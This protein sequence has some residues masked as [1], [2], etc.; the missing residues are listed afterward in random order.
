MVVYGSASTVA[1]L[2]RRLPP[3]TPLV[4]YGHRLSVAVFGA[5]AGPDAAREVARAVAAFDQRGCVCPHQ[6]FVMGDAT[7]ARGIAEALADALR[8]LADDVPIGPSA[9]GRASA[10]QQLRGTALARRAA[11]EGVSVWEGPGV[12]W[13][14]VLDPSP[15]LR[16][17]CLGRTVHVTPIRG[18]EDLD[19]ILGDV[20]PF[21][22]TVGIAGL[23][24]GAEEAVAERVCRLGASRVVPVAR[25]AFPPAWWLHDGQGPLRR[26][27]RWGARGPA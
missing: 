2:R 25:M 24:P 3:S 23:P 26:L 22:Q 27:V 11:G 18:P 21:L 7:M 6:V 14:V 1:D 19:G 16:P 10:V 20:A 12:D 13:T 4:E 8:A 9:P 17:S 15:E 5:D